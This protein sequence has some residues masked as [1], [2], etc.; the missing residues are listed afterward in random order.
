MQYDLIRNF[1]TVARTQN[2]TRA[3]E[4]LYVSQ[5]T[6]S[7][8]LQLLEDTLSHT[9][10]HRG[11][12]KR[13]AVLTE[14]GQAFLPIAEKWLSLWQETEQFRSDAPSSQLRVGCVSSLNNCLLSDF[15]MDF[16]LAHPQLH[17]KLQV[18]SSEE[19]YQCLSRGQLDVGITL[20]NLPF[21]TLQVRPLLS[22]KM[23]CVCTPSM[24]PDRQRLSADQLDTGR[25]VLLNWGVEFML[26]HDF[27]FPAGQNPRMEVNEITLIG[28]AL[29][30]SDCWSILPETVVDFFVRQGL[31]RRLTLKN[32][33]PDRV[34]YVVTPA[35]PAPGSAELIGCFQRELDAF[36]ANSSA[37]H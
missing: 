29:R 30:R 23:Y 10:I 11:R 36:I 13:L 19:I 34:S 14:Q 37:A 26:W 31:C 18:L 15:F 2:I 16:S 32:P 24:F 33:P 28:H 35:L 9:L 22:E 27:R 8:R 25:E 3:A 21:Q 12:G 7:H 6:V 1:V 4:I 17:L 20:S 5:S